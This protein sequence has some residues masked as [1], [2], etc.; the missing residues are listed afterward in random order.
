MQVTIE[1][2]GMEVEV[3]LYG[4][5]RPT[6][7]CPGED[8]HAE[9]EDVRISDWD[10]FAFNYGIHGSR[11]CYAM[12]LEKLLDRVTE[13]EWEDISF[14]A[15]DKVAHEAIDYCEPDYD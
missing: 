9:L 5:E 1:Y 3:V 13:R 6:R 2:N 11:P 10:E 12:T 7:D 14:Q 4:G 15:F 8:P